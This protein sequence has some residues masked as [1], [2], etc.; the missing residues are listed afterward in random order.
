MGGDDGHSIFVD[1]VF[2][3]GA[4]YAVTATGFLAMDAN[5]TYKLTTVLSNYTGPWSSW[6]TMAD[7]TGQLWGGPVSEA[8]N[9]SMNATGDFDAVPEPATMLLFGTGLVGLAGFR[10]RK[11]KQQQ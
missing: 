6:F 2:V 11:K 1:D 4:G 3:A 5:V 9:I 10:L 8:R 7:Q